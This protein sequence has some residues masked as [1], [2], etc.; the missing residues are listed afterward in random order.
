MRIRIE[1]CPEG[2]D[3]KAM[4]LYSMGE[5]RELTYEAMD[6]VLKAG[7]SETELT[8]IT[9]L[10][11]SMRATPEHV[12]SR[13]ADAIT[14]SYD[15]GGGQPKVFWGEMGSRQFAALL[16]VWIAL[17]QLSRRYFTPRFY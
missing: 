12:P 14:L 17:E 2:G 7:I 4:E 1:Y 5:I 15:T 8:A 16:D 11:D 6:E 9:Q 3:P 13:L 10:L